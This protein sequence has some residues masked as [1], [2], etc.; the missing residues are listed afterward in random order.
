MKSEKKQD[1]T[2]LPLAILYFEYRK[3]H[4]LEEFPRKNVDTCAIYESDHGT[5]QLCSLPQLKSM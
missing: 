4:L 3:K 5:S 1:E 2:D